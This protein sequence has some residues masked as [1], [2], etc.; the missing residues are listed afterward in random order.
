MERFVLANISIQL[1]CPLEQTIV[2]KRVQ[3]PG[4]RTYTPSRNDYFQFGPQC[5]V[6]VLYPPRDTGIKEEGESGEDDM[7][8]GC[9]G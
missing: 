2:N 7:C 5:D 9:E 8:V 3:D 1:W 4:T 6:Q